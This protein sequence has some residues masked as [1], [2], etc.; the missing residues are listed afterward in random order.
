MFATA[1]IYLEQNGI[2]MENLKEQ[3]RAIWKQKERNSV[4]QQFWTNQKTQLKYTKTE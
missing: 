1:R 2:D 3:G 4:G